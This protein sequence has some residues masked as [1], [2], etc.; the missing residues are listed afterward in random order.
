MSRQFNTAGPSKLN[1]HYMLDPLIRIDAEEIESLIDN[2]RYFVLHAPRQTGK[3]TCLLALMNDLNGKGRY[4]VLYANIESAQTARNDV[5]QGVAVIASVIAHAASL[6]LNEPQLI[7]W[8]GKEGE[9]VPAGNRLTQLLAYW[10]QSSDRPTVLLIDEVD[11]LVGDTLVSLLRQLRTGYTQRPHAFPQAIILCG[12]R[13]I[14]DYRIHL[15][16]GEIITGGSAFNI[17]AKSLRL[18]NFNQEECIALW[19]QHEAETGQTFDPAI[20]PELWQDTMGQPW[21]VNALAHECTWEDRSA[22]DRTVP[23]TLERYKAA[24]ERLILRRDTHLDQLTDKL[25]EDRVRRIISPLLSSEPMTVQLPDDDLQYCEDLGLIRRKPEVA[26]SNRIY[27]EI[28]P[29][30]ITA[31]IQ[32]FLHQPQSWYLKDDRHIDMPKLMAAF[33][34]FFRE[35]SDAWLV[36][37]SYHEA[38]PQLLL[39]AFLQRIVN[40]GGRINREYGLGRKRVDLLLEWPL[41]PEQGYFGPMQRVVIECKLLRLGRSLKTTLTDGLR[42]TA[43]YA[44]RCAADES[45]L[46]IFDRQP[47]KSWEERVWF[48]QEEHH[49]RQIGVWGA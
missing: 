17:K 26:I 13:D 24:R 29:R 37:F 49:G 9:K 44:D 28:M 22:R 10:T 1:R 27:R 5:E 31:P 41:D 21:L 43:D 32:D 25:K 35:H 12:I 46:I 7:E 3:T 40:G 45:Y 18:G 20:W 34:Q 30:V 47:G 39:Q 48:K 4:R 8:L 19:Q 14:R 36:G 42:Q 2:E 6:Y 23:I 33:Q 11:A 15:G 16:S 38:G